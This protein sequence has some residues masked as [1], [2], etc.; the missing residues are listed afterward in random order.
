MLVLLLSYNICLIVQYFLPS[1]WGWQVLGRFSAAR[2]T[3]TPASQGDRHHG[4]VMKGYYRVSQKSTFWIAVL[5]GLF[6]K[7]VVPTGSGRP[8]TIKPSFAKLQFR[9]CRFLGHPV[10]CQWFCWEY[11]L[12]TQ[13]RVLFAMDRNTDR[14]Y[15]GALNTTRPHLVM[16]GKYHS[17]IYGGKT[18][19]LWCLLVMNTQCN[20]NF[21]VRKNI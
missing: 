9:K 5:R 16:L 17:N 3:C 6:L 7:C 20:D 11:Q 14:N 13:D 1:R 2:W 4:N 15:G 21:S 12:L 10:L 18:T 19:T 8:H